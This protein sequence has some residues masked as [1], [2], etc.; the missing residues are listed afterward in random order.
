MQRLF[1]RFSR[2]VVHVFFK[3]FHGVRIHGRENVIPGGAILASNHASYYDPP[4][5]GSSLCEP[6]RFFA[7]E[8]LF[9]SF[10]GVLIRALN[11][12]P[13]SSGSN[14]I[15]MKKM[16]AQLIRGNKVLLFP[17]G[18]RSKTGELGPIKPG[19]GMLLSRSRTAIIPVYVHGT[20]RAWPA[21][22]SLPSLFV[23]MAVVFGSAIK[24]EYYA[25]GKGKEVRVRI[26][27]DV[28]RAIGRL[29]EWYEGGA[30][31]RPP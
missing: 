29:R 10:F 9:H 28:A 3:V 21:N 20:F 1:Y 18:T 27:E 5:V 6:I 11:A 7:Q 26:G 4:L 14:L 2:V 17:E 24:W 16:C 23:K 31:G 8:R 15:T 13:V 12:H 22:K 19:I 30:E 25:T